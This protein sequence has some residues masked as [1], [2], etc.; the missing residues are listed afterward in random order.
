[1]GLNDRILRD[2]VFQSWGTVRTYAAGG[3]VFRGDSCTPYESAA[4][5]RGSL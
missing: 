2:L 1:M 3:I 5:G 4:H